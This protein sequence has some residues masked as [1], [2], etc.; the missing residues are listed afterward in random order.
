MR[1]RR[2]TLRRMDSRGWILRPS[3]PAF[4]A[5]II[6]QMSLARRLRPRGFYEPA[7]LAFRGRARHQTRQILAAAPWTDGRL[8]KA[9]QQFDILIAF[10]AMETIKRH[11]GDFRSADRPGQ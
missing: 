5:T 2:S 1:C 11:R 6:A 10:C 4:G 3:A 9:D 7:A 8:G